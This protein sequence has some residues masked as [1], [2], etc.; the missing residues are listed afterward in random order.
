MDRLAK[1]DIQIHGTVAPGFESVKALFEQNMR[2]LAERHN[3]LCIYHKGKMVVDLWA[4]AVPEEAFSPDSLVNIFSSGKSFEAIAIAWAYDQGVIDYDAK[5]VDYWPEFGAQGKDS[6]TVAELMRHEAGLAAFQASIEPT[7]LL[8]ENIKQ[9]KIGSLIE[10]H[11]Q[12]FREQGSTRE[13]HAITRGWIIN[14]LFRR[15][16]PNGRTIGEFIE[17]AIRQPLNADVCVGVKDHE[18]SRI[19]KVVP[20]SGKFQ[21]WEGFKPSFM[22]RRMEQNIFQTTGK[23]MA[24]IPNMRRRTTKGSPPPFAGMKRIDFFNDPAVVQG[25]TPSANTNATARGLAKV[26]AL[27][28][29]GGALDGVELLSA[30]AWQAMHD[31]PDSKDMGFAPT[32][33]TQGG[34][35]K[36]ERSVGK[37]R[38]ERAFNNGREGFY[39]WMGLGGSIF[40][41][42]PEKQ[43]GFGYVPTSLNVLDLLN[44]RGK[45]YQAEALKSVNT[46]DK[47]TT[48]SA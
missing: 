46:L 4:S 47:R 33:F 2:H 16:D 9:N 26:A 7:D 3:Q 17:E 40:Q 48:L 14:E 8:T 43:I 41:W 27:M 13:Y 30:K 34:V 24:L 15:V 6:L 44:E 37:S 1:E 42:N 29:M 32:T 31:K 10:S 28:S 36:F 19:T 18:L 39:G 35:A 38:L 22:G 23:I 12:T 20:L 25:E 45:S 11:P 21:F 5:I